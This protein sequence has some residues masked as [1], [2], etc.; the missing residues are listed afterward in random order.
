MAHA[1][2]NGVGTFEPATEALNAIGKFLNERLA[3]AHQAPSAP[4]LKAQT[5]QITDRSILIAAGGSGIGRGLAESF[6]VLGNRVVVAGRIFFW[7][8]K[9]VSRMAGIVGFLSFPAL[10][11]VLRQDRQSAYQP[12]LFQQT[13]RTICQGDEHELLRLL[14]TAQQRF[15]RSALCCRHC[16]AFSSAGASKRKGNHHRLC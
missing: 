16:Y 14:I 12:K 1:F 11:K 8:K 7:Q 10:Q 4:L 9:G 6:H 5:M 2:V 13:S 15:C 3:R